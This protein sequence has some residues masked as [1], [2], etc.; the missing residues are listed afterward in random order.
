MV[1]PATPEQKAR[2]ALL[3]PNHRMVKDPKN[4]SMW[5][6]KPTDEYSEEKRLAHLV[7]LRKNKIK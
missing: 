1:K 5:V 3:A 7:F 6:S 4:P 2:L